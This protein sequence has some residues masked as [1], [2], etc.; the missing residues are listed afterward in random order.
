MDGLFKPLLL[1]VAI[2]LV[3]SPVLANPPLPDLG[4]VSSSVLSEQDAKRI[5]EAA[6]I[7]L[8]QSGELL[9]DAEV[10]TYLDEVGG[11]LVRASAAERY[12]FRFYPI[13]N[14]SINAFAVPGGLVGVNTGLLVAAQ[15]ESEVAAVLAHEIAHVTQQHSARMQFSQRA[16]PWVALASIALSILAAK[17]GRGDAATAVMIG[18][19][20]L[21]LQNQLYFSQQLEEEADY[22]GMQTLK[23]SG[24]D[25]SAMPSFFN[26]LVQKERY[27]VEVAPAFLRTHPVTAK[28]ISSSEERLSDY[29]YRQLEDSP[30]FLFVREKLKV[31]QMGNQEALQQ[32][33]SAL[34]EK[35]YRSLTAQYYGLAFAEYNS[36]L[37]SQALQNV[38]NARAILKKD[39]PMLDNLE[40]LILVQQ[41]KV[42]EALKVFRRGAANYPSSRSLI[43]EEVETLIG[44]G[45]VQE[46]IK[47][48]QK[49]LSLH[50]ADAKLYQ[51]AAK[52]YAISGQVQ[53]QYQMQSEYHAYHLEYGLAIEMLEQAMAQ[54][55][56]FYTMSALE[57]RLK[58]LQQL[59]QLYK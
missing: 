33:H 27:Q 41:G 8:R 25:P 9:E 3:V 2:S 22:I 39:N 19:P 40:G 13:L 37:Y 45:R 53:K 1:A 36:K 34:L 24:F 47:K 23:K 46:A 43:Y 11:R 4:D 12:H 7:N 42:E 17:S 29:P 52:A 58:V 59:N 28:R 30:N 26:R 21:L 44:A 15:H 16:T 49:L 31:L 51:L 57:A 32:H 55:G 10:Q 14:A 35:R 5:S 54:G 56:D 38:Q 18:G 48:A 6:Y 50:P 20:G